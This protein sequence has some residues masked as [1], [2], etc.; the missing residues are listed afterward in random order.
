[1]HLLVLS[2]FRQELGLARWRISCE[3]QCTFWCS[4][5]SDEED[6]ELNKLEKGVSMHLL[7]LSAF[8]LKSKTTGQV[9][10]LPSQCT[11]WCSVLSDPRQG[12]PTGCSTTVSMHLLV[13]SA[14]RRRRGRGCVRVFEVSMHLLV[15]SAFRR[16]GSTRVEGDP[17]CRLNAPSGAQCFPTLRSSAAAGRVVVVSQCTF[18][19][20]VL[21]DYI[22]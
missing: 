1:M 17:G 5:L 8:R 7:V 19:C 16:R 20:S 10:D 9:T 6:Q 13:L 15:L 14:F 18:W 2:A 3:S 4:V 11:F 21:S 22:C 12:F